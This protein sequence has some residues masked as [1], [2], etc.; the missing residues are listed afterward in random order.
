MEKLKV[1]YQTTKVLNKKGKIKGK[2]KKETKALK[3]Q[4]CHHM[5]NKKMKQK[6]TIFRT[7]DDYAI[8]EA[9]GA[10]FPVKVFEDDEL[11]AR[12]K[13]FE[14]MNNQ[15]KY[16]AVAVGAGNSTV[17][18]FSKVG[19]AIQPFKKTYKKIRTIAQ[20]KNSLNK[21]KNKKG[22]RT[23]G[24]SAQYGSWGSN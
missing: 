18:Y 24:G 4:C 3:A 21:K 8:C 12:I 23:G 20:K 16:I 7:G 14:E 13:G 17:E 9:C 1:V 19:A 10:R 15:A 11:N 5:Y 6:P 22:N 2:N